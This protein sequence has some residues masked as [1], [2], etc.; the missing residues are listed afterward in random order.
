MIDK[1]QA[2][3]RDDFL[4]Q[5]EHR[6]EAIEESLLRAT[7][8]IYPSADATIKTF[9]PNKSNCDKSTRTRIH[10]MS[11]TETVHCLEMWQQLQIRQMERL[12]EAMQQKQTQNNQ[13]I[14]IGVDQFPNR[15]HQ[16]FLEAPSP[17]LKTETPTT[18]TESS[19]AALSWSHWQEHLHRQQLDSLVETDNETDNSGAT[20]TPRTQY[21]ATPGSNTT[22]TR[23]A[24]AAAF[25]ATPRS[26]ATST[27]STPATPTFNDLHLSASTASII[28]QATGRDKGDSAAAA[29]STCSDDDNDGS[30]ECSTSRSRADA[31]Y[32]LDDERTHPSDEQNNKSPKDPRRFQNNNGRFSQPTDELL[33]QSGQYDDDEDTYDD[34]DEHTI[35]TVSTVLQTRRHH[36]QGA[37]VYFEEEDDDTH[38]NKSR[39]A[40]SG[41]TFYDYDENAD[42]DDCSKQQSQTWR[43]AFAEDADSDEEYSIPTVSTVLQSR[44]TTLL[45]Q[46]QQQQHDD[47]A[48]YDERLI[49]TVSGS[50]AIHPQQQQQP[51]R[52]D[53]PK[54]THS[55]QLSTPSRSVGGGRPSHIEF[56]SLADYSNNIPSPAQTH[57]TMDDDDT[58]VVLNDETSTCY[59]RQLETVQE[60]DNAS[61]CSTETPVLD[62]YRLV[63]DDESPHGFVVLPN[64][65]GLL[66]SKK[67]KKKAYRKSPYPKQK[68]QQQPSTPRI[69]ENAPLNLLEESSFG[70][71]SSS[72]P[73]VAETVS[74]TPLTSLC[75]SASKRLVD[76]D[77]WD[78]RSLAPSLLYARHA[79]SPILPS[80]NYKG[81]NAVSPKQP[82][83]V[84]VASSVLPF[85]R[86]ITKAEYD[87]APRLIH[88]QVSLDELRMA[89]AALN[90]AIG[91]AAVDA[92]HNIQSPHSHHFGGTGGA[93]ADCVVASRDVHVASTEAHR[94][95]S[96]YSCCFEQERKRKSLLFALCYCKRLRMRL[97][98]SASSGEEIVYDVVG[99]SM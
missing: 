89:V 63:H 50:D 87:A 70:I 88:L 16:G 75:R 94:I 1:T 15:F 68:H 7:E 5:Q 92:V 36:R 2:Q 49:P 90:D 98:T 60:E 59:N 19:Q 37:A 45:Q 81:N 4:E 43:N 56:E 53:N 65:R 31:S 28:Y 83:P 20:C 57:S 84:T 64:P 23:A 8:E 69:D 51:R 32:Y 72:T 6:L 25:A 47:G 17:L 48:S 67:K 21:T 39:V 34:D 82:P 85:L 33:Q 46:Q 76:L 11:V 86:S 27:R 29:T 97:P 9:M 38:K 58:V 54:S 22:F 30:D 3:T 14:F 41:L 77:E 95:L 79:A 91:Q 35:P 55:K 26:A 71:A 12:Q 18:T 42:A 99:D 44:R 13:Q 80:P 52:Q 66:H 61:V 24:A 62:R 78:R 93:G 73:Y 74:R 10:M 96:D 40:L